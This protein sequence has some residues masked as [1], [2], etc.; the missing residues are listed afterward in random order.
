MIQYSCLTSVHFLAFVVSI[1]WVSSRR[2]CLIK[3]LV[4]KFF[5][6]TVEVDEPEVVRAVKVPNSETEAPILTGSYTD[7]H[8]YNVT[9]LKEGESEITILI[10][11][12][13]S[14]TNR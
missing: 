11:N 7:V 6:F 5:F 12:T 13:P 14:A 9:C 4:S 1:S 10:G 8:V 3:T 2:G